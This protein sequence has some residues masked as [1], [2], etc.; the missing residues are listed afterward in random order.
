MKKIFSF[1]TIIVALALAQVAK[2]ELVKP[3]VAAQYARGILGMKEVPSQS[4]RGPLR[5]PKHNGQSAAPEF[6][7]FNNP[8][9]G[10]VIISAEDRVKPVIAYSPEGSFDTNGMPDNLEWWMNGVAEYVEIVRNSDLEASAAVKS[11]WEYLP[12]GG[13]T[14][15]KKELVTAKWSQNSPFNDMCPIVN[16]ETSRSL[17]GCVAVAMAIVMQYN[18]WPAHGKGVIGGYTTSSF[19]TYVPPFSIDDHAYDWDLLSDDN[20]LNGKAGMMTSEQKQQVAQL[21]YDCGVAVNMD[22]SSEF[23][24][25]SAGRMLKAIVN[26]MSYSESAALITR[27]SYSLDKWYSIIKNEIDQDRVVY[28][29]GMGDAGGHA[30]VCDG[31]D[32]NGNMVHINWGWGSGDVNGF[33]TLDLTLPKRYGFS[34]S[35]MQDAVIYLAPETKDIVAEEKS[36]I[37]FLLY[38]NFYGLQPSSSTDV[39]IGSELSFKIGWLQNNSVNDVVGE[40][41]V[42]LMDKDGAV[43]QEGW[44]H[45][46]DLPSSNGYIYY[47][48]TDPTI[49]MVTP[50]ITD[51]FQLFIKD[52]GQW[53][54]MPGNH[55][56]LPDVDGVFCGVT[57]N[58]V[59]LVNGT[60]AAGQEVYLSLT[61]GFTDV[62]TVKWTVNGTELKNNKVTLVSGTNA[63]I[64]DVEYTDGTNG[65][66]F[67]N[68]EL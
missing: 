60:C 33:Y 42:C 34:F 57:D 38:R 17:A 56:L 29:D 66:I 49:L 24:G 26:N 44:S 68:L 3:E 30:F 61:Y 47:D 21:I 11:A 18:K 52:D 19:N 50:E 2:A 37:T 35:E 48:V 31:Y 13:T 67:Y 5:A 59:I 43:K 65:S 1:I 4:N 10:W 58:P 46:M 45:K 14:G 51:Y 25:S 28:Y 54:P 63:I 41:K 55:D 64:A 12:L 22:F 27:S 62:K 36:G 8:E 40:F 23:S 53:K 9:G 15:E 32:T 7:V 6:Y 39:R 20:M 16:T